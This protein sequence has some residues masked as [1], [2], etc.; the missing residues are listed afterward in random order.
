[1]DPQVT[2]AVDQ[3]F[4]RLQASGYDSLNDMQRTLLCVWATV[5]EVDNGGFEQFFL[6]TSGDWATDTVDAFIMIGAPNLA[7]VVKGAIGV[8]PE[9]GPSCD[10]DTRR[11]QL[12]TLSSQACDKLR[13]QD[14]KFD[15]KHPDVDALIESFVNRH[16]LELHEC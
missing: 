12:D 3:V 2:T 11:G 1:M 16:R 14:G 5:G 8:F 6:N 13:L 10:Q 4:A 9:G 15:S 7:E